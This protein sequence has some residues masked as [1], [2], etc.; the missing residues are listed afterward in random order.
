MTSYNPDQVS[1]ATIQTFTGVMFN[2]NN[3]DPEDIIVKDISHALSMLC[4]YGGHSHHFYSVAEH[5]VLMSRNFEEQG[6]PDLARAALMHDATEAYMGDV[7]RPIKLQLPLYQEIENGLQRT[8][9]ARFGLPLDMP[10]EVKEADL[11]ICNDE[12]AVLMYEREWSIDHL[13]PL[14]V[15]IQHWFPIEA[16]ENWLM[17][18]W[19]LFA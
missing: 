4:R 6:Q 2:V 17:S 18:Y 11:R 3:P 13:A 5:S 8:I 16:E 1:N 9:F 12:R 10:L 14:G 15:D 19:G 7:V